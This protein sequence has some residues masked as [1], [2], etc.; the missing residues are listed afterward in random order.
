M[1]ALLLI[2]AVGGVAHADPP[3]MTASTTIVTAPPA[4]GE[5]DQLATSDAASARTGVFDSGIVLDTG[6]VD[7]TLITA[8]T[9]GSQLGVAV[10]VGGGVQLSLDALDAF[11][12][13]YESIGGDVRL[14]VARGARHSIA[15]GVGYHAA[16]SSLG[17]AEEPFI[18]SY[19]TLGGDF[20]YAF[21]DRLL[22]SF[23]TGFVR[24]DGTDGMST[25]T[26]LYGHAGLVYGAGLVRG[27][28]ELG[29]LGS[30]LGVVAARLAT[31]HV[32]AD[33][34]VGATGGDVISTPMVVFALS[35]R[36]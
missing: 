2:A 30:P 34:G 9:Q 36:N 4:P 22:A 20:A 31:R 15:V 11:G 18:G 3:G 25:T 32:S 35:V 12:G 13:R 29:Y 6:K 21:G 10:G 16:S 1:R 17:Q 14:A 23:G 5:L 26:S 24:Y 19:L 33:L 8:A 7:V 28:A 27:I